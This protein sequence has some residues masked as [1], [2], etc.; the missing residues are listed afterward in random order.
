MHPPEPKVLKRVLACG[1]LQEQTGR[2]TF[3]WDTSDNDDIQ[4]QIESLAFDPQDVEVAMLPRAVVLLQL[5]N[6]NLNTRV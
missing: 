3:V 1:L 4:T 5:T 2:Q 6:N